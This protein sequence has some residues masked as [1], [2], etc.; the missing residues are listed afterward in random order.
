MK[1]TVFE[2]NEWWYLFSEIKNRN[3]FEYY[4]KI[5][6]SKDNFSNYIFISG[7]CPGFTLDPG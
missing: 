4:Y 6:N 2:L 3:E 7:Y 1:F 5:E